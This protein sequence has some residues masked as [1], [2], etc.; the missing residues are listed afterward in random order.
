[1]REDYEAA[2]ETFELGGVLAEARY[3]PRTAPVSA[4]LDNRASVLRLLERYDEALPLAE[5]ALEIREE[6]YPAQSVDLAYSYGNLSILYGDLERFD[7]ALQYAD[8]AMKIFE[9][10]LGP[11]SGD[12]GRGHSGRADI[13]QKRGKAYWP[14]ALEDYQA[15]L[16][17]FA[18]AGEEFAQNVEDIEEEVAKLEAA[19]R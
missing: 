16:V 4:L 17:I 7:D 2:L 15:A 19:L 8:R 9:E 1:M 3:G 12:L 6:T 11:S 10:K 18:D 5:L 13:L 14:R